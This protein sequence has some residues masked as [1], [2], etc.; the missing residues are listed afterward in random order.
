MASKDA[1][2]NSRRS[3]RGNQ[4]RRGEKGHTGAD[5]Q[6]QTEERHKKAGEES[7]GISRKQFH[8]TES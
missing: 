5:R 7:Q 8:R 6:D 2:V 4:K 1:R 3:S